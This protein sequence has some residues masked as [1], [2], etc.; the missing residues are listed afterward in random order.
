MIVK[1]RVST[2]RVGSSDYS[3]IEVDDEDV[4]G[5]SDE[6]FDEYMGKLATDEIMSNGLIDWNWEVLDE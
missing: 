5:L 3:I 6:E 4:L 2:N 1:I